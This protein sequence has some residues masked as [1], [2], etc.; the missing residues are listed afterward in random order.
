MARLVEY[1]EEPRHHVVFL[2]V[3]H[4]GDIGNESLALGQAVRADDEDRRKL[5]PLVVHELAR[6]PEGLSKECTLASNALLTNELVLLS[7]QGLGFEKAPEHA[8]HWLPEQVLP[9]ILRHFDSEALCALHVE[10][11]RVIVDTGLSVTDLA[12]LAVRGADHLLRRRLDI[13]AVLFD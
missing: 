8:H 6:S 12:I 7:G 3:Y 10:R 1:F 5:V 2:L 9:V 11:A 4:F 13:A